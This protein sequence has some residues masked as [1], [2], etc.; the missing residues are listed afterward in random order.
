[1]PTIKR[2]LIIM[3]GVMMA[4]VTFAGTA[5][6]DTVYPPPVTTRVLGTSASS[7]PPAAARVESAGAL[8]FTGT[9][10][11]GAGAL[12]GLLLAGGA[13]MV[14]AGKRRKVDA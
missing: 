12:G 8:A 6:A 11:I 2:P 3:S 9:N 1:M 10:A 7:V 4:M 14:V 5:N 13:A